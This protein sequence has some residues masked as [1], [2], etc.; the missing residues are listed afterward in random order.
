MKKLLICCL[1]CPAVCAAQVPH[2]S[3]SADT[4]IYKSVEMNEVTVKS[5]RILRKADRFVMLV[6][7]DDN[8]NAEELL[9]QTPSVSLT[10]KRI[11]ILGAGGTKV[12][13]DGK[14][15]RLTGEQLINYLRNLPS[16]NIKKVEVLPMADA[17]SD[18]NDK[19][20]IVYIH[21]KHRSDNGLQGNAG[22]SQS[23]SGSFSRL[24]PSL[25]VDTRI[26]RWSIFGNVA[27]S[28]TFRNDVTSSGERNY[29]A[30][31]VSYSNRGRAKQHDNNAIAKADVQY[32]VDSMRTVGAMVEYFRYHTGMKT[33]D[34]SRL[35]YPSEIY[36]SS[37]NYR[38]RTDYDMY[39]GAMSYVRKY[40]QK[41]SALKVL[42]DYTG[43]HSRSRNTYFISRHRSSRDTTY[44]NRLTADYHI[45]S[46]DVSYKKYV[47]EHTSWQIGAKGTQIG[48]TDRSRY[49]GLRKEGWTPLPA[50]RYD[51]KY[52]E[53]I[54]ASFA[55]CKISRQRIDIDAGL[56]TEYTHTKNRT[57]GSSKR[58]LDLYPH[59]AL[60]YSFDKMKQWMTTL[61]YAKNI[62]RPSFEALNPNRIQHSEY[63]YRIGNPDLKPTYIDN[64]SATLVYNYR[65]I[66]SIG[67]R[68]HKNLIR[69]FS[70]QDAQNP[71]I[72]YIQYENHR[73]ED[74]WFVHI[75]APFQPA[76]WLQLTVNL[77]GVR[78]RIQMTDREDY[79]HHHLLFT[80]IL[81]GL[82]LPAG[83]SAEF[84]YDAYSRLYSGNSEVAPHRT[85]DFTLKK[86]WKKNKW[87]AS[88]G[89]K[90][91]FNEHHRYRSQLNDYESLSDY[92]IGRTGRLIKLA[93]TWNFSRGSK[94]KR[95]LIDMSTDHSRF[96]H[97]SSH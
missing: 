36:E 90:N 51:Y 82:R 69:E 40:D 78:Q 44:Q 21:L 26:N 72:S 74:H 4:A 33:T 71:N 10:D 55:T 43:K 25:T 35:A 92:K 83:Y 7:P 61:Q 86:K 66:L 15:V 60:T 81:V 96:E 29:A 30:P 56:R 52:R 89:V 53:S 39:S 22:V 67:G 24:F 1:I 19:G 88:V 50:F 3:L 47:S 91:L 76:E 41:G 32:A 6:P 12:F 13:V 79:R 8:Q 31:S 37:G 48:M 9:R 68:L 93:V 87:I 65:F 58:Y 63:S 18:A 49:E 16:Q 94:V 73:H 95:R 57:D 80:N 14:E 20:G 2:D 42:A 5:P 46:A 28:P 54:L 27:V 75:S 85:L 11:S 23:V 97:P 34:E 17:A 38:Q 59:L 62:E 77:T 64:I 84:L 70:K 45:A